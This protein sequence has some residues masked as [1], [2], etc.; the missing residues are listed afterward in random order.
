M[1]TFSGNFST[2]VLQVVLIT[3]G[4]SGS[5]VGS[6]WH[7]LQTMNDRA[8]STDKFPLPFSFAC[9]LHVMVVGTP[10]D[11]SLQTS[12]PLYQ[13]LVDLCSPGG[14]VYVPDTPLSLRSVHAMFTRLA[15]RHFTAQN[16]ILQCGNLKCNVQL[17]PAPEK[18]SM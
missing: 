14:G 8:G 18:Y 7:S 2:I 12:L 15:D 1:E 11:A 6:L 3:D 16:A 9:K 17:Y 13:R 4:N 10:S 5:G